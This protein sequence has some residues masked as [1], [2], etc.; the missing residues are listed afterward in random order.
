MRFPVRMTGTKTRCIIIF[1]WRNTVKIILLAHKAKIGFVSNPFILCRH[2]TSLL[3]IVKSLGPAYTVKCIDNQY[4]FLVISGQTTGQYFRGEAFAPFVNGSY[5]ETMNHS[6]GHVS[7][8]QSGFI[9][10][11]AIVKPTL[12]DPGIYFIGLCHCRK[13]QCIY[14]RTP[15][16]P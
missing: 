4:W 11:A 10:Q 6:R 3:S 5:F 7:Q 13:L 8:K 1:P 9:H 14:H 16:K 2:E 15:R 12:F